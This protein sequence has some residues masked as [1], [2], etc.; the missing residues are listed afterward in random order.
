[1]LQSNR[2]PSLIES[3]KKTCTNGVRKKNS[4]FFPSQYIL[5]SKVLQLNIESATKNDIGSIGPG[6]VKD[7]RLLFFC[8]VVSR[9]SYLSTLTLL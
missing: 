5:W 6:M 2:H 3:K 7:A 1:M 9:L 8:L 4:I